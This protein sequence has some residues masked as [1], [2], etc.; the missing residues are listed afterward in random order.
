[1]TEERSGFEEWALLELMGHR[2]LAGR[3]SE[4]V[5]GGTALVR[6]DVPTGDDSF[7]TQ[8]YGGSAMYCIT[9]TTE[10]IAR[11]V[12]EHYQPEPVHPWELRPPTPARLLPAGDD[13]DDEP[14]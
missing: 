14:F 1:M 12:A 13:D 10:E 8:Y 11:K 5:I 3:V 6:I 9:P 2:K 4:A 7:A